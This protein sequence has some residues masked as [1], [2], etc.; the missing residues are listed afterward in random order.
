MFNDINYWA[1]LMTGVLSLALGFLW[2]AVIWAKPYQRD[3][4][5][6]PA[7]SGQPSNAA[8]MQSFMIYILV[9]F[10]TS[11]AYAV[12]LELWQAGGQTFGYDGDSLA[13]AFWFTM[14]LAAGFTLPFT[15]GK[16]VWQFKSWLVVA[17]DTSYEVIRFA[18]L[19]LF[20]WYWT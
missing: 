3:M 6:A 14:L 5:G 11:L 1:V 16:K 12:C 15:V 8:K 4:Y 9:S 13:N 7:S 2:M 10:V 17:V 20:F 18:M 19:L